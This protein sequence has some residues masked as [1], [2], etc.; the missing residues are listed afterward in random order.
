MNSSTTPVAPKTTDDIPSVKLSDEKT[1]SRTKRFSAIDSLKNQRD[2]ITYGG[3]Y[4]D[5]YKDTFSQDVN[6]RRD[7]T[8]LS[9]LA[10]HYERK[11]SEQAHN[12]VKE[13]PV[14]EP[15]D[16]V[17]PKNSP[18]VERKVPVA[19]N[20]TF[21]LQTL[22]DRIEKLY[23][24]STSPY[25]TITNTERIDQKVRSPVSERTFKLSSPINDVKKIISGK[26]SNAT[27]ELN[28][29][30]NESQLIGYKS[31]T[32]NKL[33]QRAKDIF[34]KS[35]NFMKKLKMKDD[36]VNIYTVN[37]HRNLQSPTSPKLPEKRYTEVTMDTLNPLQ[38]IEAYISQCEAE[39]QKTKNIEK[40][41]NILKTV[42]SSPLDKKK[43]LESDK[44]KSQEFDKKQLGHLHEPLKSFNEVENLLKPGVSDMEAENSVPFDRTNKARCSTSEVESNYG[45]N[46]SKPLSRTASDAQQRPIERKV[47]KN[48]VVNRYN[49][50]QVWEFCFNKYISVNRNF[51]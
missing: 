38:Q 43:E 28:K 40:F 45:K 11:F 15:D 26:N 10:H 24:T 2:K 41:E 51:P 3:K 22:S 9:Y 50:N 31:I 27:H 21:Q 46:K 49:R 17:T 47:E 39:A 8:R 6:L 16:P 34:D 4:M 37:D 23:G 36:H 14:S 1:Q 33:Q 5:R 19:N 12:E 48:K 29:S 35:P 25:Y 32:E 44:E 20:D 13:P 42:K 18:S 30:D 7:P